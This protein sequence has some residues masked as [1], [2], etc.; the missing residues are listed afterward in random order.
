MMTQKVFKIPDGKGGITYQIQTPDG[1]WHI[2]DENGNPI[3]ERK[4]APAE[5]AP[6]VP[7]TPKTRKSRKK[8]PVPPDEL[9]FV[10][11]SMK[12][13]KEEHKLLSSYVHW[14]NLSKGP[15]TRGEFLLQLGLE[16][17]RRD[18]EYKE[19]LKKNPEIPG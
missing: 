4:E 7:A 8:T 13:S 2:T 10:Q 3:P 11:F 15:L 14:W 17:V 16:A 12:I 6:E 9:S 5:A 19:F 18:K 1:K